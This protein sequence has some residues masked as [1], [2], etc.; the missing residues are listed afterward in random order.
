[1]RARIWVVSWLLWP[2]A[3]AASAE[4]AGA[5]PPPASEVQRLDAGVADDAGPA[6]A[7]AAPVPVNP[8]PATSRAGMASPVPVTSAPA[9]QPLAGSAPASDAGTAA[10]PDAPTIDAGAPAPRVL[11]DDAGASA[12]GAQIDA[13]GARVRPRASVLDAGPAPA[14]RDIPSPAAVSGGAASEDAGAV[15]EPSVYRAIAV[16]PASRVGSRLDAVPRNV[17]QIDRATLE[18]AQPLG[19]SDVLNEQLGSVVVNDVQNNPLQP[20]LQYRGYTA[21]PLLGTPQGLAVYQNAVRVNDAFGDVVQWDLVP[22]FA[23]DEI[24]IMPGA[25]PLYGLNALGGGMQ[26]RMKDGFRTAGARVSALA[27]SFGRYQT[28]AEYARRF[29]QWGFYGGASAFGEQGFRDESRSSRQQVYA[30]L[31]NRSQRQEFGLNATLVDSDLN[32]NGPTPIELL[33]RR[34]SALYTFPDNTHNRLLMMSADARRS[35]SARISLGATVYF[36]HLL[37]DTSNGDEAEFEACD[38]AADALCD[39]AGIALRTEGGRPIPLGTPAYDAV[40]NTTRSASDGT[41]G[42]VHMDVEEALFGRPNRFLV[43]AAYD[44]STIAFAQRV[45][46]GRLTE[47]RSVAGDDVYIGNAGYGTKLGVNNQHLGAFLSEQWSVIEHAWLQLSARFDWSRIELDDRTS[48]A[49]DGTHAF[50]RVNPAVGVTYQP[51]QALTLF[52]SYGESNRTPS[53]VELACADPDQPCRVPN[54]FVADPPLDQV[55]TR[56]IEVGARGQLGAGAAAR[57]WLSWSLAGF[58]SRNLH[59]ILFVAGSHVGTGFFRNAGETQRV[60]LE[61]AFDARVGR[62]RLFASYALLHATF[63]SPLTLPAE[64]NPRAQERDASAVIDVRPGD[65]LS[66]LPTHSLKA[67]VRVTP[68]TGW[69]IGLTAIAQSSKPYR[70]DEANLIAGVPGYAV[71]NADSTYWLFDAL[72]LVVKAHNILDSKYETFG[73]LADPGDVVGGVSNPRFLSPG[74]PF[75]IW[76]G[77]VLLAE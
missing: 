11:T 2:W 19:L 7:D 43:G 3:S 63:E 29:G 1:M 16:V 55:V 35:L 17:Q 67:G 6:R 32:G 10:G 74:A 45:E 66:G 48:S 62:L 12:P 31:R 50:A 22:E 25:S 21:S 70:G 60:G 65:R 64:G 73:V 20:D 44:Q 4:D 47:D 77:L 27:G 30:D 46:L 42:I 23:I 41:G 40:F 56:S 5:R 34:R 9:M 8:A 52:A 72:Q 53:A 58:G 37:R 51:I 39:E 24:Q 59:D 15:S 18:R 49:L 36:K 76:A 75:G 13:A 14:S 71:L 54:A 33:R 26:L 68:L 61:A 28:S 57:P 69:S 38:D